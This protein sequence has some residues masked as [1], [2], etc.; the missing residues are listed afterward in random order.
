VCP[1]PGGF[2]EWSARDRPAEPFDTELLDDAIDVLEDERKERAPF[3][4]WV[5]VRQVAWNSGKSGVP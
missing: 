4:G 5:K 1:T 2:T 3:I